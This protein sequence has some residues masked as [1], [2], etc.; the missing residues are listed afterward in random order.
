MLRRSS[1]FLRMCVPAA[2]GSS[3]TVSR[4]R[5]FMTMAS[6]GASLRSTRFKVPG[7]GARDALEPRRLVAEEEAQVTNRDAQLSGR[8]RDLGKRIDAKIREFEVEGPTHVEARRKALDMRMEH[9]RL[10]A[11]HK[12]IHEGVRHPEREAAV[13]SEL[14]VTMLSIE[15]WLAG[16][17]KKA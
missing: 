16:L 5:A 8:L 7:E 3:G 15:R 17:D 12:S 10:E 4:L 2:T 1:P 14:E 11:L 6:A 13:A 9:T